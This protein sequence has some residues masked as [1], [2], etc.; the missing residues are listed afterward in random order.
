MS[1]R[2]T[3]VYNLRRGTPAV[4]SVEA[5][6]DPPRTI[7]AVAAALASGGHSVRLVE[8]DAAC[9]ERLRADPPDIVVNIAEGL[10]GAS[11]EAHVP[12]VC[13]MLGIPFT[14]SGVLTQAVCQDKPFALRVLAGAGLPTTRFWEVPRGGRLPAAAEPP[15]FVKPAREGSSM[16]VVESSLCRTAEAVAAEVARIH[17]RFREPA[18]VE[19][20]LG[21]REFTVG[22]LDR[23]RRLLPIR[24]INFSE[25]PAGYPPVY[26]YRFKKEWDDPR[27][28]TCPP[29]IPT[30]LRTRLRKL[31]LAAFDALHCQ[32]IAR[33]DIRCDLRGRPAVLEVNPLPGLTPGYSD[34]ACMA[35]VAGLTFPDLVLSVLE[36]ACIRYGLPWRRA[37]ER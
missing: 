20:F 6:Y 21:G 14:G 7:D 22:V 34:L 11:R 16:G 33:V 3:L 1:L 37:P 26:T 32:D 10:G 4:N 12:A 13:E 8:A 25:V 36:S 5:E 19:S 28:F 15:L 24:E 31:A 23:P 17:Q 29:E 30:A 9:A 2:V 27:F 18:L 35:E